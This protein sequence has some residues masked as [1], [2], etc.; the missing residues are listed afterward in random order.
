MAND[1]ADVTARGDDANVEHLAD[2][3]EE[4]AAA[5]LRLIRHVHLREVTFSTTGSFR[6]MWTHLALFHR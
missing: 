5:W 2:N 4:V 6:F 3:I 1:P